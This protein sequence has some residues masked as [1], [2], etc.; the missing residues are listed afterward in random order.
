MKKVIFDTNKSISFGGYVIHFQK[1][2]AREVQDNHFEACMTA[3]AG[4][5]KEPKPVVKKKAAPKKKQPIKED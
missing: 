4:E 2:V 5:V 1:G 3:G